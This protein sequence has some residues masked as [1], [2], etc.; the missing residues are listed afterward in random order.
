MTLTLDLQEALLLNSATEPPFSLLN[1]QA[2]ISVLFIPCGDKQLT[3][4]V[5]AGIPYFLE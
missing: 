3:G 4:D 5:C 1:T 2:R